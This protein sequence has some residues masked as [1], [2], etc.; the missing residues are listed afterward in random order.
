MTVKEYLK[1]PKILFP[2]GTP[3][4]SLKRDLQNDPENPE[5]KAVWRVKFK[6]ES[7]VHV[8]NTRPLVVLTDVH[9]GRRK[10]MV[11]I[12]SVSLD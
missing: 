6:I 7:N 10:C 12:I 9:T 3:E 8:Q 11:L 5:W 2:S 4:R 1:P